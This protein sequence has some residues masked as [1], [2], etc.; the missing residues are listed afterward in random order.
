MKLIILEQLSNWPFHKDSFR[1]I[2]LG[3]M[4][5]GIQNNYQS[6]IQAFLYN[7]IVLK[8]FVSVFNF[9]LPSGNTHAHALFRYQSHHGRHYH[10]TFLLELM[11]LQ[12]LQMF[13][14]PCRIF[15][16][17]IFIFIFVEQSQDSVFRHFY[18]MCQR[19]RLAVF[20]M[21]LLQ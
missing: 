6:Y 18:Q 20:L 3:V 1:W 10:D 15:C 14:R 13:F 21:L 17:L 5:I 7:V 16:T 12:Q 8:I 19:F 11:K 4:K 2:Q 9:D